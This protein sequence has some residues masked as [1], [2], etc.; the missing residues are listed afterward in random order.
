MGIG[1]VGSSDEEDNSES[2][3]LEARSRV[4]KPP[5]GSSRTSRIDSGVDKG[6]RGYGSASLQEVIELR[7]T[8]LE[9]PAACASQGA[10]DN[11]RIEQLPQHGKS[12]CNRF[13]TGLSTME[14]SYKVDYLWFARGNAGS[15]TVPVRL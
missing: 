1:P 10:I 4:E 7:R 3:D 6:L 9:V 5:K 13:G 14:S 2:R 12:F 15:R 11:L 8:Q